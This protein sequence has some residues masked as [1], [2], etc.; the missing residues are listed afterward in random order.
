MTPGGDRGPDGSDI[1]MTST[2]YSNP[3]NPLIP[4]P[5][6]RG[7]IPISVLCEMAHTGHMTELHDVLF[8]FDTERLRKLCTQLR[9]ELGWIHD[10][11]RPEFDR[12]HK[13]AL[14]VLETRCADEAVARLLGGV[15]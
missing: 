8:Q 10:H 4:I 14:K 9:K 5:D 3:V 7:P 15:A 12:V 11:R 2:Y 6:P 13:M 1:V